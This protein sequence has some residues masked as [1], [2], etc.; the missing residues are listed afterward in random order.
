MRRGENLAGAHRQVTRAGGV[1]EAELA[2]HL[3]LGD[4]VQ[5]RAGGKGVEEPAAGGVR[6]VL[7]HGR[8]EVGG[9]RCESSQVGPGRFGAARI[10]QPDRARGQDA[11]PCRSRREAQ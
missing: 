2:F 11:Q 8:I 10:G 9:A 5:R 4:P 3:D 6:Q 1:A 7:D